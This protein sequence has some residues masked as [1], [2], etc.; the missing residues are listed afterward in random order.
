MTEV[1]ILSTLGNAA[2]GLG[3]FYVAP[4]L[5][6]LSNLNIKNQMW[7][8]CLS[9]IAQAG[10]IRRNETNAEQKSA[11]ETTIRFTLPYV[12]LSGASL[13]ANK[14][15]WKAG[16]VSTAVLGTAQLAI[17]K[18]AS[19]YA[20]RRINNS[21]FGADEWRR[22]YNVMVDD[23]AL[24]ADIEQRLNQPC[25]F[26]GDQGKKVRDT[27]MLVLIPATVDGQPFNLAKLGN[28]MQAPTDI[29][30]KA[31]ISPSYESVA[32][33]II[34]SPDESYWLLMTKEMVPGSID[35]DYAEQETI[36]TAVS[37]EAP[38]ILEA[39]TV[40]L[41][42]FVR[43]GD[44]LA[45]MQ[46]QDPPYLRYSREDPPYLRHSKCSRMFY[47]SC[48]DKD[49][50]EE[51]SNLVLGNFTPGV[52]GRKTMKVLGGYFSDIRAETQNSRGWYAKWSD[53]NLRPNE[54]IK[55]HVGVAG[56]SKL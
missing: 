48:K 37:Y 19:S 15:A 52:E 29:G 30:H 49:P 34:E 8:F 14:S 4:K 47:T 32:G 25:P 5:S 31:G 16:L 17:C 27:H 53:P 13:Y 39:A 33:N 41:T 7:G 26:W 21:K 12:L 6:A 55:Y 43:R 50:L 9:A 1:T 46:K 10:F 54:C 56:V 42:H 23:K 35:K 24:P 44:C 38:S 18:A 45:Y 28:L 36:V 20:D 3:Y 22:Y 40:L 11:L 2:L 51:N